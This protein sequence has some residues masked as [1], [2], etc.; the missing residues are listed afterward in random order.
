MGKHGYGS[1]V[2]GM[3]VRKLWCSIQWGHGLRT[4]ILP[5]KGLV[6]L[7]PM[8]FTVG[9]A[10]KPWRLDMIPPFSWGASYH[11]WFL[12]V[13]AFEPTM[14]EKRQTF[15]VQNAFALS[16]G[17]LNRLKNV[18]SVIPHSVPWSLKLHGETPKNRHQSELMACRES[19]MMFNVCSWCRGGFSYEWAL[20]WGFLLCSLCHFGEARIFLASSGLLTP[21]CQML[22]H[23]HQQL[24]GH[25]SLFYP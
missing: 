15:P 24:Q 4:I 12:S 19:V 20:W 13:L 1:H 11:S 5:F 2:P 6:N 7:K 16:C 9:F 18:I 8:G 21:W 23:A 3:K 10:R 25:L 14:H 22:S 17:W